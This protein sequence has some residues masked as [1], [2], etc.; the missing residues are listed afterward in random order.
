MPNVTSPNQRQLNT[1]SEFRAID[2]QRH[3]EIASPDTEDDHPAI[4]EIRRRAVEVI[5][6]FAELG[7][8]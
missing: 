6:E 3:Q 1:F 2:E 8:L 5:H 7:S 4:R